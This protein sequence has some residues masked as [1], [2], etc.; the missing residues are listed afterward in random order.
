MAGDVWDR[1][2]EDTLRG[3]FLRRLKERLDAAETAEEQREITA[4]ARF[5][6]A[7]L[8]RRDMG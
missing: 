1:C 8:D 3:L 6:L 2:G 4:A 7:A 5:G